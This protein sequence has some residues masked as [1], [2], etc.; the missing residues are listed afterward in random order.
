MIIFL[1]GMEVWGSQTEAF[2]K[3]C[4]KLE[5]TM[6]KAF[7]LLQTEIDTKATSLKENMMEKANS[8]GK[9]A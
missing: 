8:Y 1:T 7:L 3:E 9:M 2:T 5:N 6:E 4:S